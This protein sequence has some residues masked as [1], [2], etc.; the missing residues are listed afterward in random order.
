M[1]SDSLFFEALARHGLTATK[2]RVTAS[3][4]SVAGNRPGCMPRKISVID[5]LVSAFEPHCPRLLDPQTDTSGVHATYQ[6]GHID[7]YSVVRTPG[8]YP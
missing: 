7:I 4:G 5:D 2:V 8:S 6:A 1:S 3:R